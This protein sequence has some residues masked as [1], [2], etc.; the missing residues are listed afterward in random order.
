MR[1]Y[2][3]P[4]F[5]Y[6]IVSAILLCFSFGYTYAYFSATAMVESTLKMNRVTVNWVHLNAGGQTQSIDSLSVYN[7]DNVVV[8]TNDLKHGV[9]VQMQAQTYKTVTNEETKETT[10][11]PNVDEGGNNVTTNVKLGIRNNGDV[12]IYCRIKLTATYIADGGEKED[13][14]SYVKLAT[15]N[16]GTAKYV[17]VEDQ[18]SWFIN[19]GYYYYGTTI[20]NLTQ[21]DASGYIAFANYVYLDP[22]ASTELYGKQVSVT[23]SLEAVQFEHEAYGS[24]WG[25]DLS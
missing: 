19:E 16:S 3:I 7:N 17:F 14:S 2:A 23:L 20:K 1:K 25:L 8:L 21:I 22:A 4:K 13:I 18:S 12:A 9:Y 6:I 10:K 5:M 11:V 24:A 15:Y